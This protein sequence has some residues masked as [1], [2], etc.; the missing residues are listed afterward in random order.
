LSR[1]EGAAMAFAPASAFQTL[2]LFD[3]QP[4]RSTLRNPIVWKRPAATAALPDPGI[5][6]FPPDLLRLTRE[7]RALD[8]RFVLVREV[9]GHEQL[10]EPT[11]VT[12]L[13]LTVRLTPSTQPGAL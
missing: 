9:D 2:A 3:V 12:L 10:L 1:L 4:R 5:W 11:W 8:P 7:E 13:P 6:T